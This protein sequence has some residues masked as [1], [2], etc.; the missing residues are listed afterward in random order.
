MRRTKRP[1]IPT[2]EPRSRSHEGWLTPA[3]VRVLVA[4]ACWGFS[5]SSFYLLPTYLEKEL[6][7]GPDTVG[8]IIGIFGMAT[9]LFTPLAGH[10]VDRFPRRYSVAAGAVIMSLASLG[11]VFVDAIDTWLVVL[12]IA[13]GL[14]YALVLVAVGTLV[15]D[16]VAPERL[17]QAL[18]LSGASMLVMNALGPAIAEPLAELAGWQAVFGLSTVTA[19][20]S[21]AFAMRVPEKA[22]NHP[23][24]D[25]GAS[26]GLL[27][28]LRRPLAQH[29][30]LI[31]TLCGALFGS[32]ITFEQP[33][34]RELGR[35][36]IGGFF[37][38]FAAGALFIRF[39]YGSVP[40]RYGRHRVGCI[41]LGLY[42]ATVLLLALPV[43]PWLEA[44]GLAF[45]LSHGL[46]Y[47]SLNAI[48]V[49]GVAPH[50]RGRIMAIFT[51]SF[52]LGVWGGATA[53]GM[54]AA[55]AGYEAVFVCTAAIGAIATVV[56]ASSTPLRG[57]NIPSTDA[58]EAR[59]NWQQ[60]KP[61]W[62]DAPALG[63]SAMEKTA[64][65]RA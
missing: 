62:E 57:D 63:G 21:A 8:V 1:F 58:C 3:L 44:I 40:D 16:S 42:A 2:D 55:F 64:L 11:Y 4:A 31:M 12:R 41:S 34:A 24:A 53:F 43:G 27:N 37:V 38:A 48:A 50:E 56:F 29:Y 19:A 60:A 18:G 35:E 20:I 49:T 15:A 14:S 39:F 45:G 28:V 25:E 10:W 7:A 47:P 36:Y 59:T 13:Q 26:K 33:Y 9:V 6:D 52:S 61:A 54:L 5:F 17:S 32:V 65:E 51:G 22:Q 46:V 30:A 23:A